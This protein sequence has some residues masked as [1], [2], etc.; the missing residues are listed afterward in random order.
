MS[1]AAL[2]AR[3]RALAGRSTLRLTHHGRKSGRPY[4]V[5]IWFVVDGDTVYLPTADLRRQWT[6]NVRARPEVLLDVDGTR[7]SGRVSGRVADAELGRVV[8]LIQAKYWYVSPVVW[9]HRLLG[10]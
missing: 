8:D 4:E 10:G 5:T 6:R 7:L 9:L 3:L 1:T 2:A